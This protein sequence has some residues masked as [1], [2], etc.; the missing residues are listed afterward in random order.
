M[1]DSKHTETTIAGGLALFTLIL[2]NPHMYFDKN[3]ELTNIAHVLVLKNRLTEYFKLDVV[4][5]GV[6]VEDV[7]V[8]RGAAEAVAVVTWLGMVHHHGLSVVV[9]TTLVNNLQQNHLRW[10]IILSHNPPSNACL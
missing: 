5:Q 9:M 1:R 8:G 10:E 7:L 3:H 2:L 6:V 4:H